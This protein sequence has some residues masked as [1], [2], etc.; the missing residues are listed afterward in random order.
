MKWTTLAWWHE[1]DRRLK[2][3]VANMQEPRFRGVPRGAVGAWLMSQL[4]FAMAIPF[5]LTPIVTRLLYPWLPQQ[6]AWIYILAGA[7]LLA[8]SLAAHRECQ[9]ARD[10]EGMVSGN[11]DAAEEKNT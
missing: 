11:P 5:L 3:R 7:M 8:A 6:D 10:A 2:E 9:R 1:Q 4:C